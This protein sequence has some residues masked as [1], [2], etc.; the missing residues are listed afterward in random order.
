MPEISH[1]I[2]AR[3]LSQEY[4]ITK[5]L[6]LSREVGS[7]ILEEH[8]GNHA[9]AG[10]DQELQGFIAMSAANRAGAS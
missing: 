4:S 8:D 7:R 2:Y 10:E 3:V 6:D 5:K 9:A 1:V